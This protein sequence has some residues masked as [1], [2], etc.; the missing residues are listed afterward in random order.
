MKRT[1]TSK[2][3]KIKSKFNPEDHRKE[4]EEAKN[5]KKMTREIMIKEDIK[6]V[7]LSQNMKKKKSK[8]PKKMMMILVQA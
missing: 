5:D 8:K 3:S 2:I 7:L 4:V 1:E 6:S